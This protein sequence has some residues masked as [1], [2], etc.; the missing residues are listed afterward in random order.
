MY[1]DYKDDHAFELNYPYGT[2][3]DTWT[4]RDGTK[5]KLSDMDRQYIRNCM[6]Y[7]GEDN[8][9]YERFRHELEKRN[10]RN[11]SPS[12]SILVLTI[13]K[14]YGRFGIEKICGKMAV[15]IAS[16]DAPAKELGVSDHKIVN[17]GENVT[18]LL[19]IPLEDYRQA[20]AYSAIFAML[21]KRLKEGN[22]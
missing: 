14:G 17:D 18:P 11:N 12:E 5:I 7:V 9:W 15:I 20:E 10:M 2:P 3:G 4:R 21:A 13:P 19:A 22:P 6:N 8:P 1:D 16:S